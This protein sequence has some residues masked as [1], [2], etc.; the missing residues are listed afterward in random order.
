MNYIVPNNNTMILELIYGLEVL[1]FVSFIS[2]IVMGWLGLIAPAIFLG[3][4]G[5]IRIALK[6]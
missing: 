1:F 4:V 2:Y 3:M 6:D 5:L